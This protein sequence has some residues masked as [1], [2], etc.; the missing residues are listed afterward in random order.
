MNEK[1]N[2][3]KFIFYFI[4]SIGQNTN[5]DYCKKEELMNF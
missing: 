1:L 3:K 5:G 2:Y 4:N